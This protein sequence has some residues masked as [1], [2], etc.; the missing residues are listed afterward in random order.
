MVGLPFLT[1]RQ[2]NSLAVVRESQILA[3]R[4]P[5]T[6]VCR[7]TVLAENQLDDGFMASPAVA[8]KSLILRTEKRLL[9]VE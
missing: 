6:K 8:G 1:F 5:F 2:R 9:R 3:H 7:K 4:E